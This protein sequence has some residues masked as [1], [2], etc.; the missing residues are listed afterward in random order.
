MATPRHSLNSNKQG[1][2]RDQRPRAAVLGLLGR[3]ARG[4]GLLLASGVMVHGGMAA[5]AP[6]PL[7]GEVVTPTPTARVDLGLPLPVATV[8]AQVVARFGADALLGLDADR[9]VR[10]L[11]RLGLATNGA[12]PVVFARETFAAHRDLLG[13]TGRDAVRVDLDLDKNLGLRS[14]D[15]RV[16]NFR[17]SFGGIPFERQSVA[18]RFAPDGRLSEIR[19]DRTPAVIAMPERTFDADAARMAVE[20]AFGVTHAGRPTL[21]ILPMSPVESRLAWRVPT[22]LIPLV[23]HHFVW[24][25]AADGTVIRHEAAGFDHAHVKLAPRSTPTP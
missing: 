16:L 10:A 8:R 15:G 3:V 13:L 1:L 17:L 20:T 5:A 18:F 23:A 4:A 2:S 25:D 14:A 21:V 7:T 19:M 11:R 22:A 6:G 24:V 12:D 9:Q